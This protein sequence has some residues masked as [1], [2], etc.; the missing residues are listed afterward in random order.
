M[1]T[2]DYTPLLPH[3]PPTERKSPIILIAILVAAAI[4]AAAVG[5]VVTRNKSTCANLDGV[6]DQMIISMMLEDNVAFTEQKKILEGC[7]P[8]GRVAE[9]L[10][11]I[12]R[13][14]EME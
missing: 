10:A 5:L 8:P 7:E 9:R 13:Y 12:S 4:T 3:P 1:D 11:L 2:Y 14:S 6:A